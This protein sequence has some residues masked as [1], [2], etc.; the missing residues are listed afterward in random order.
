MKNLVNGKLVKMNLVGLD[1]NAFSLMGAFSK[2]A[3]RQGW[4]SDD[5]D[6]VLVKCLS[7]D[8]QTLL[9]TLVAH[10]EEVDDVEHTEEV[11]D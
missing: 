11:D 4:S 2:N 10:T 5:I 7:S 3:K 1:G 9:S 8:Y 6:K